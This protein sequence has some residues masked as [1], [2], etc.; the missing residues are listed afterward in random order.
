MERHVT[1]RLQ[2]VKE[3]Q[4]QILRMKLAIVLWI[5][6]LKTFETVVLFSVSVGFK[7]DQALRML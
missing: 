1:S 5:F 4:T 2:K 6:Q 3:G 7:R